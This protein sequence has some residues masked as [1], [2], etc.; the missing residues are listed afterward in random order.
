MPRFHRVCATTAALVLAVCLASMPLRARAG[1]PE[2]ERVSVAYAAQES[3]PSEERFIGNVR[4]YTTK[5]QVVDSSSSVRSFRV[6]LGRRG[7]EH[8]GVLVIE[9]P[10]GEVTQREIVAPDCERVARGLAIAMALAIDPEANISEVPPKTAPEPEA[11]DVASEPEHPPLPPARP[12][13]AGKEKATERR[14]ENEKEKARGKVGAPSGAR[15]PVLTFALEARG[16]VTSA[17]VRDVA[18]VVGAAVDVRAA[19]PGVPEW[20]APSLAVGV[21][22][23]FPVVVDAPFG[24]SEF[25]WT[26]A[27]FRLCPVRFRFAS[28]RLDAVPC[29]E[30]NAGVLQA[31]AR[32][33][34]AA[35]R[36]SS[37]WFDVGG[38][39]RVVYRIGQ[40]VGVGATILVSAPFVRHR[41]AFVE[42]GV[43]S[44]AP[45]VGIT[46]GLLVE[47]RF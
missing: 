26:T 21:R 30:A 17:V 5:W 20:L 28:G 10:N 31:E 42:G 35:R 43:V 25:S 45:P 32:T 14:T 16:E 38:S 13:D 40:S 27:M 22:Q 44:Q 4:R 19:P 9:T 34:P 36:V 1:E 41:F 46:G 3:C 2:A 33:T 37:A 7:A 18:P 47:W 24:S 15:R 8:R 39:G 12:E 29:A 6:V 11:L 23:S